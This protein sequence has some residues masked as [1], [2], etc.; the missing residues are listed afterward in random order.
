MLRAVKARIQSKGDGKTYLYNFA[1]DS[2]TQNHYRIRSVG[3]DAKGVTHA[4]ELSYLWK[5]GQGDVPPRD[6]MEYEAIMRFVSYEKF[7]RLF[8]HFNLIRPQTSA[9]MSFVMN[10]DP[11]NEKLGNIIWRPVASEPFEGM[12]FDQELEFK[13]LQESERVQSIWEAFYRETDTKYV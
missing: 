7:N 12:L 2:P 9:F 3:P 11:N 13:P 5:N 4:D 8:L 6:S 1:V 10:G